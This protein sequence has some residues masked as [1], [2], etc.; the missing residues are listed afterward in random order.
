MVRGCMDLDDG[1]IFIKIHS[2][3]LPQSTV[4]PAATSD[5]HV[6][7]IWANRIGE[8]LWILVDFFVDFFL[9]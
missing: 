2:A 5:H 8:E 7:H 3:S 6:G 9:Q 1:K 4:G